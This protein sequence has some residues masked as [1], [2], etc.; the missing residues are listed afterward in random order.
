MNN[1]TVYR[2]TSPE[3]KVYIGITG[4]PPSRRWHGGSAYRS[5]PHFYAAIKKYGW[6]NFKHEIIAEHL[7]KEEACATE[8]QL[9]RLCG[10]QDPRRG[11]NRSPGG[12]KTTLGYHLSEE[13]RQKISISAK[14]R[15]AI[16]RTEDWKRKIGEANRGHAVSEE[17]REK[18]RQAIGNRFNT[19]EARAKQ[20]ENTPRGSL[21]HNAK[22]VLCT[23]TGIIYP[24]LTEAA[25]AADCSYTNIARCC[26]GKQKSAGGYNWQFIPK[27]GDSGA[28]E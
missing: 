19:P 5:N 17:T 9:I 24:T 3:G 8:I 22:A 26:S 28:Q 20:R 23:D 14:T 7:T 15:P 10:S 21:H 2:H 13:T 4:R 27:A 1:Y 6:E 18:L 12:D 25:R 11:Y 16:P